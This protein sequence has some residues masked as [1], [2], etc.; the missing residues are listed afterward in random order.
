MCRGYPKL[1]RKKEEKTMKGE[2]EYK[3]RSL[4]F[5]NRVCRRCGETYLSHAKMGKYCPKCIKPTGNK[6][7][8]KRK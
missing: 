8:K 3:D 7:H 1:F 4:K 5:R 2:K 6:S